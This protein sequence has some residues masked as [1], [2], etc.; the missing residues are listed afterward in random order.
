MTRG[1]A[2]VVRA[3]QHILVIDIRQLPR[4][5][6]SDS[7]W[8]AIT[9]IAGEV[10]KGYTQNKITDL[11]LFGLLVYISKAIKNLPIILQRFTNIAYCSINS[12]ATSWWEC[13]GSWLIWTVG[14]DKCMTISLLLQ[15]DSLDHLAMS[16][17]QLLSSMDDSILLCMPI[18]KN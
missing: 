13:W 3:E 15:D 16:S 8:P 2:V 4:L 7:D 14:K 5:M 18:F 17:L 10:S 11:A 12:S 6:I 1:R 9:A